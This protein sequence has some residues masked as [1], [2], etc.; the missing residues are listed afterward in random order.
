MA[1]APPRAYV[2]QPPN[3]VDIETSPPGSL[4]S[5]APPPV[6]LIFKKETL[7]LLGV[8]YGSVYLW[9]RAG[10]FPL[11]R[12]IGPGGRSAR[13]AWYEHEVQ[14]WLRARPPRQMKPLPPPKEKNPKGR[15]Q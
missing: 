8:S 7:A 6:R 5:S 12:Q 1:G 13:I 9:M 14:A 2:A 4:P 11:P 15:A 3:N 10:Q